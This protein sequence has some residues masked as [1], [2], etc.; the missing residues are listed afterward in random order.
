MVL[1]VSHLNKFN[2]FLKSLTRLV[3]K[4][5]AEISKRISSRSSQGARDKFLSSL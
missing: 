1:L 2:K 4:P 5:K 3:T